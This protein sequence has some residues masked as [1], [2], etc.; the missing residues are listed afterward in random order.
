MEGCFWRI[1]EF[2]REKK[3]KVI[4]G[5]ISV[6]WVCSSSEIP[7][8]SLSLLSGSK[9]RSF[10]S[11]SMGNNPTPPALLHCSFTPAV[12][13]SFPSSFS[14]NS[15]FSSFFIDEV[16]NCCLIMFVCFGSWVHLFV[17]YH[18][19]THVSVTL[20][21]IWSEMNLGFLYKLIYSYSVID[22]S[23]Y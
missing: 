4:M 23:D 13:L 16:P 14:G 10:A 21:V 8:A 5:S 15:F 12:S 7:S 18:V 20:G 17:F 11:L 2:G 1:T 9:R 6:A 3:N 19:Q 22:F